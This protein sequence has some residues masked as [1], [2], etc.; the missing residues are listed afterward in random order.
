MRIYKRKDTYWADYFVAGKRVRKSLG[1]TN[2]S[3]A[4]IKAA[5]LE[6][7]KDTPTTSWESFL[8]RFRMHI[9]A[10]KKEQTIGHYERGIAALNE[11]LQIKELKDIT[12][13]L[14]DEIAVTLK[15]K[16]HNKKFFSG[17]N[18]KIR[19]IKTMMRQAE[20]WDLIPP[21]NWI[22]VAKFKEST[23]RVEFHTAE[24]LKKILKFFPKQWKVAILLASRAGLR[25]SEIAML[26]WA[27]IDFKNNQIY[28]APFKT[29]K[30]RYVPISDDLCNALKQESKVGEYVVKIEG[31][32]TKKDYLSKSYILIAEGLPFKSFMHKLRHT[33]A[34]HLVQNGV[35][36]YRVS[37][38]MG[39][40]SIKMTEKYAHLAPV[41][42]KM[43]IKQL[44]KI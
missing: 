43:A 5:K 7:G 35:D 23:N 8:V 26:K 11:H 34:S 42:F 14:V 15:S 29:E 36:L 25:R 21:Q 18:R 13:S 16:E 39:H 17:I 1:T 2:K 32:R 38:L 28:V 10:T 22:K 19:A 31:D 12:P 33:F 41:D 20:F 6:E 4:I 37:K 27:D 9:K 40:S 24:E 44:P 3:A 30:Y